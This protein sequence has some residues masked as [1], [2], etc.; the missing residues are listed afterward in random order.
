MSYCRPDDAGIYIYPNINGY[1]DFMIMPKTEQ[2]MHLPSDNLDILLYLIKTK[3]PDE[4]SK[5]IKNGEKLYNLY[6]R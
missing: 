5:R 2:I 1:I 6:K 4:L 3:Y